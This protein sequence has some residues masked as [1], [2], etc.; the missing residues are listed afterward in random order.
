MLSLALLAA[1]AQP[2]PAAQLPAPLHHGVEVAFLLSGTMSLE[3]AGQPR[4]V[5]RAGDSFTIPRG[6]AHNGG[7]P[8]KVPARLAITYVVDK[9]APLRAP[10]VPPAP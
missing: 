8:G 7:N 9:G 6:V 5:L 2:M 3:M 10:V 4:R 1:A